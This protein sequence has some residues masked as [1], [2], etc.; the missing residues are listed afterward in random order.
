MNEVLLARTF[1]DL[2]DTLVDDYETSD[3]LAFLADRCVELLEVDA[4]GLLVTD[5]A[6]KLRLLAASTE[7]AALLELFEMQEQEGPCYDCWRTGKTVPDAKLEDS[8]DQWPRFAENARAAGFRAVSGV[9]LRVRRHV[10]GALN[11]FRRSDAPFPEVHL[12]VAQAL[13]NVATL[14]ILHERAYREATELTA[15]LQGAL[16]S[17]VVIEQAKGIVAERADI[18]VPSAFETLRSYARS[19]SR[20]LREVAKEVVDGALTL[21]QLRGSGSA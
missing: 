21:E 10:I 20:P 12:S 16:D 3:F 2:A 18:S 17:R 13:A 11:L 4:A 9:P 14:G 6:G 19:N 7:E 5:E 8:A 1:V 15:Q